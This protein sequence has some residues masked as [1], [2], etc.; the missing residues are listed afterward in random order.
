MHLCT[1]TYVC[2]L[3]YVCTYSRSAGCFTE[4]TYVR[5]YVC[6]CMYVRMYVCTYVCMCVCMYVHMYICSFGS[7]SVNCEPSCLCETTD[8][9]DLTFFVTRRTVRV[10][11]LDVLSIDS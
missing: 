1:Y 10:F 6:V 2:H 9:E 7:H 8:E 5:A 11:L 3:V 4:Y